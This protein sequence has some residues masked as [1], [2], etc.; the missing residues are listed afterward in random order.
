MRSILKVTFDSNVL[1]KVLQP[2]SCQ[3]QSAPAIHDQQI[4]HQALCSGTIEGFV[5]KT[6]FTK[7]ATTRA[8]REELL[9][10]TFRRHAKTSSPSL[11]PSE[12]MSAPQDD[13]QNKPSKNS[14]F[15]NRKDILSI[16]RQYH[17]RILQ[18]YLLGDVKT[19][20]QLKNGDFRTDD[21][22]PE[23]YYHW[24]GNENDVMNRNDECFR[25]IHDELKAGVLS[26]DWLDANDDDHPSKDLEAIQH[27][28]NPSAEEADMQ[29]IST[30]YAHQL[31]IFCTEDKGRNAGGNSVMKP[32]N[33]EALR[34]K[35]GIHFCTLEELA[36]IVTESKS[37][38]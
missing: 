13:L 32:K 17:V 8:V 21:I 18:T 30:H 14:A 34:V 1:Q 10:R 19:N 35:F 26:V 36:K 23:D 24:D 28:K 38:V 2:D 29:A 5:S 31:D 7:E 15:L 27:F 3:I 37:P 25:F 6:Y 16:M 11:T 22:R 9:R 33:K 4:V 12:N 20:P